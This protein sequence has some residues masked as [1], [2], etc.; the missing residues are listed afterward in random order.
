MIIQ[1]NKFSRF[2]KIKPL[3]QFILRELMGPFFFGIMSFTIILIAGSLLFQIADLVIQRGVSV[4]VV[5]RLFIYYL[6]KLMTYTIPMSCLLATLTGFGRLSANSELVALK[7]AGLSFSRI[8]RP[9][10]FATFIISIAAFFINETIVP[11]T[12]RAASNVM[13]F[14]VWKQSPPQFHEKI[15]I[16]EESGGVLKRVIYINKM[17][18]KN[19]DM[20]Q[21]V[22]QEFD[23]GRLS[24]IN[25]AESANW[26]D[27]SWWLNNGNVFEINKNGLVSLLFKFEKQKINI[28]MNP[29]EIAKAATQ[30]PEQ[31]TMN[32]LLAT[33]K[34]NEKSGI[35]S[36]KLW[37]IFHLRISV[38]WACMVLALVGAALG[39]RPQR[40]SSS[41][42]LGLS[43][44]I[45]FVYYVILSL[46]Q[47]LGDAGY[48]PSYI[49]AWI[50]NV[51]FLIIG[52][53]MCKNANKLG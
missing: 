30:Q 34:L 27:G 52:L 4:W 49:A 26:I 48:I 16:K 31:M 17:E 32:E 53:L 21:V 13:L 44:I 37:M 20:S 11:L 46:T 43:V 7:A 12:E 36:A 33:I 25:S 28:N 1:N 50:A 10:V 41:F 23:D 29:D 39:S 8:V 9:V 15:F 35:N 19:G 5:V 40:S 2:L 45:V 51:V 38:P 47:S 14:E 3:D 18:I 24:R 42:G 22:V 6:P